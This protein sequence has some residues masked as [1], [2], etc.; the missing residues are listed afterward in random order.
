MVY[1]KTAKDSFTVSNQEVY[2]GLPNIVPVTGDEVCLKNLKIEPGEI[3]TPWTPHPEDILY[4]A[5]GL[6]DGILYDVSGY[7][8]NCFASPNPP[9][10][11]ADSIRYGLCSEFNGT[12]N[13][14]Y[15][16]KKMWLNDELT[17]T[18]WAYLDDWT[19]CTGSI[20]SCV[21][22]GGW[23]FQKLNGNAN[24]GFPIGTGVSSNTYRTSTIPLSSFST[25]WHFFG[26][27]YD[28]YKATVYIDGV[29][30]SISAEY[31]TKT[32][33]FYSTNV[34]NNGLFIGGESGGNS[35]LITPDEKFNGKISD[36]RIYAT[37]LSAD[38][39]LELYNTPISLASNGTL[40]SNTFSES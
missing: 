40:L 9:T 18:C 21:E 19:T 33:I 7:Q 38:D 25:G 24:L 36:V 16:G 8:N 11:S 14:Y 23:G 13:W 39:I 35:G 34:N 3:A 31:S 15:M 17:L 4:T 27:T 28:G 12:D 10:F 2:I 22:A 29:V 30:N 5:M 1:Y 26:L 6:D 37:A 32:P 20:I